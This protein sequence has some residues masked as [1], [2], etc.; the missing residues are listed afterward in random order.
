MYMRAPFGFHIICRPPPTTSEESCDFLKCDRMGRKR[1]NF[2][3]IFGEIAI[4]GPA[5]AGIVVLSWTGLPQ[6]GHPKENRRPVTSD[7][8]AIGPVGGPAVSR[9]KLG[10]GACGPLG[11]VREGRYSAAAGDEGFAAQATFPWHLGGAGLG[12]LDRGFD[13]TG[14][15]GHGFILMVCLCSMPLRSRGKGAGVGRGRLNFQKI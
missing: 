10:R 8:A 3:G 12:F 2:S 13:P 15:L 7:K 14:C 11:G 5:G 6:L 4:N 9:N 1:S